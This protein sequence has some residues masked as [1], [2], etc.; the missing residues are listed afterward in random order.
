MHAAQPPRTEAS[1]CRQVFGRS[2][3][4]SRSRRSS[5][6]SGLVGTS[7]QPGSLAGSS[8]ADGVPGPRRSRSAAPAPTIGRVRAARTGVLGGTSL[9]LATGAHVLG[10][11]SLPDVGV[12]LVAGMLLGLLAAVLTARRVRLPALL[13]LLGVQQLALHELFGLAA[14]APA[15][16]PTASAY[17]G[18]AGH[19]GHLGGADPF[20]S[21]CATAAGGMAAMP[22]TSAWAMTAAHVL[23]VLVT[24]WVLARGEAWLWRTVARVV[25]AAGLA[26]GKPSLPRSRGR[27]P[28][29]RLVTTCRN[30]VWS[31]AAP[32]GPPLLLSH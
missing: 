3:D 1:A 25:A 26:V 32:R 9:F 13:A 14:A 24:A 22:G 31:A 2:P 8:Y 23:A 18:H 10:G 19:A 27:R 17:A 7:V 11:G 5:A 30:A 4:S 12:L 28:V 21:G 6:T 29:R 20:M 15:C 16:T